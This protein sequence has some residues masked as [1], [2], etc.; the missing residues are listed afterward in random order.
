MNTMTL[1]HIG[2]EQT[3]VTAG[4]QPDPAAKLVL[5]LGSQ[6]T[7]RDYFK[8]APPHPLE[9]E[10]AIAAVEDEVT[11]AK[12]MIPP[13]SGLFT[14]DAS[15]R[16]IALYS[17]V[18]DAASMRLPIDAVERAFDRLAAVSLGRPAAHEGLPENAEFAAT[19]LILREFMHHL[20]FAQITILERPPEGFE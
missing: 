9:V 16:E 6:K 10:N 1:L 20:Q 18:V 2:A 17:G 8:H 11:R 14:V 3:V 12:S 7:A 4:R 5:A 15:V 13:G 19:L